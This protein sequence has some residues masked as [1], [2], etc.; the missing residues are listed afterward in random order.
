MLKNYIKIAWRSLVK[1]KAYA[2]LNIIGLAVGMTAVLLIAMWIQNQFQYDNFY[3]NKENIYKVWRMSELEGR[4]SVQDVTSAPPVERLKQDYPE[5]THAARM[6]WISEELFSY[7]NQ[8][9]KAKGNSVDPDFVQIFGFEFVEGSSAHALTAP[10]HILLTESFAKKLF[11]SENPM[12]KTVQMNKEK[13]YK[14]VGILQ[15]LPSYTDFEFNYLV[16]LTAEDISTYGSNWNTN[17]Y[18]SFVSLA[19][20]TDLT[21]FNKKIEPLLRTEAPDLKSSALFLYPMSKM[22][23]YASFENGVPA[24]GQIKQVKIISAL[25]LLILLIACINFMNLATARSQQRSKE[26]GVRKVVGARKKNLVYQFLI[27]STLLAFIA[28]IFALLLLLIALPI[29]NSIL[30]KAISMDWFNPI[31]WGAMLSFILLTGLLAG[32]YPAFV[33]SAF[34]P[35]RNLNGVL[36]KKFRF[37][38]LRET[39]VVLQFGIAI[40]LIVATL[41]MRLQI[42]HA[43]ERDTGY[44]TAQLLEIPVEGAMEKNYA[45]IKAELLEQQI[46]NHVTRTGWSITRDASSASGNFSWEGSTAEQEK[47]IAFNLMRAESD[48]VNSL[49]LT[50]IDGRD[51]DYA[52]RPADSASALINEAAVKEMNLTNPV[53]SYLRWGETNYTIVGVIKNHISGSPYRPITPLLIRPSKNYLMNIVIRTNPARSMQQN[54]VGIEQ[55]IKKFNPSYPFSYTFVDQIYAEKFKAQ[56]QMASLSFIFSLLAIFISCLGLFGLATYIAETRIKEIGIRKVLGASV[57]GIT[58]MLSK[59]FIKL[60]LIALIVAAPLAWWLMNSWLQDFSYRIQM[61]WWMLL[62]A[63]TIA[64]LIALFTVSFQAIKAALANPV[65]SLRS[66]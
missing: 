32:L 36:Q 65:D 50:L 46:A 19:A 49:G 17:T 26:V 30:D 66:E 20:G 22:H 15:D 18:Y 13:A 43:N 60:V 35:I 1:N 52:N 51:L 33:L 55:I 45:A 12:H 7:E 38:N 28:G 16:P 61:Q 29:F 58:G 6:Y 3:T 42:K 64:I 31:L 44:Q 27:E 62:I 2:L 41:V 34:S 9:L 4:I 53:G 21:A 37:F 5:V 56:E 11:G 10:D 25:G 8:D 48:L 23:L 40:V 59:D 47:K 14:V 54:L 57:Q 39:L 24:G 63:G